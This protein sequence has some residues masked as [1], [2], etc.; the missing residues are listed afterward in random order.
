MQTNKF[1]NKCVRDREF[2]QIIRI[3][4]IFLIVDWR[5]RG[6]QN[7][8]HIVCRKSSEQETCVQLFHAFD[9]NWKGTK[10]RGGKYALQLFVWATFIDYTKLKDTKIPNTT[11]RILTHLHS[12]ASINLS[13][14][15][16]TY[17]S[18]NTSNPVIIFSN[19]FWS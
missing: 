8:F 6:D 18:L 4:F 10:N 14:C 7:K 1:Y 19:F 17:L 12:N 15:L 11:P 13:I 5:I 3:T 16:S 9:W 2:I